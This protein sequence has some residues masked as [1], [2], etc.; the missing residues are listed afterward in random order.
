MFLDFAKPGC[1]KR[2]R[3]SKNRCFAFFSIIFSP[4]KCH[5]LC[6]LETECLTYTHEQVLTDLLVKVI[7]KYSKH[8]K[9]NKTSL[10]Q[11]P[12]NH[13]TQLNLSLKPKY[14]QFACAQH[15]F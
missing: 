15:A 5:A 4:A 13:E 3:Q 6:H 8:F 12:S 2:L 1:W 7:Q 11:Q 9:E 14:G 10:N